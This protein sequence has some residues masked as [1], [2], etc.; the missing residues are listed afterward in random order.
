MTGAHDRRILAL[1]RKTP[2]TAHELAYRAGISMDTTRRRLA[3]LESAKT[4][5]K[6]RVI[7]QHG[8]DGRTNTVWMLSSL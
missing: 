3:E 1:L 2:M 7:R 6:A 8:M 5:R 4:V